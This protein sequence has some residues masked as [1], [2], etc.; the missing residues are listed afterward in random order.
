MAEIFTRDPSLQSFRDDDGLVEIA[1]RSENLLSHMNVDSMLLRV[2]SA[3]LPA[4]STRWCL[5]NKKKG[6]KIIDKDSHLS[7]SLQV[8]TNLL[9]LFIFFPPPEEHSLSGRTESLPCLCGDG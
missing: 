2:M 9:F 8:R 6:S 1:A 7:V 5:S 4:L 3:Q